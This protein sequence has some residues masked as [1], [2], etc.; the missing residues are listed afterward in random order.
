[1]HPLSNLEEKLA[2]LKWFN[3]QFEK[4]GKINFLFIEPQLSTKDMYKALFPFFYL[5]E[6]RGETIYSSTALTGLDKYDREL[7]LA[8]L[9]TRLTDEQI[10]FADVIFFPFTTQD[11]SEEY[12]RIKAKKKIICFCVDLNFYEVPKEHPLKKYFSEPLKNTLE[13]NVNN[14][15]YAVTSNQELA[16]YLHENKIK[17]NI[18]CIPYYIGQ[19][20]INTDIEADNS[21]LQVIGGGAK[22]QPKPVKVKSTGDKKPAPPIKGNEFLE[23]INIGIIYSDLVDYKPFMSTLKAIDKLGNVTFYI[24][25]YTPD[26][27]DVFKGI[28][29]NYVKKCSI[30]YYFKLLHS[31][32]LNLC[33]VPLEANLYNETSEGI[34]RFLECGIFG[35]PLIA[36]DQYPYNTVVKHNQNGFIYKEIDDIPSMVKGLSTIMPFVN[37]TVKTNLI[38]DVILNHSWVQEKADKIIEIF[39]KHIK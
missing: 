7:Q 15:H 10:D 32:K 25:G 2:D 1:M 22:I 38:N 34:S 39:L 9:H 24:I 28:H 23:P 3:G 5:W 19:D 36:P 8:G 12:D 31:L 35:I 33:L 29:Y 4:K 16:K 18:I 27:K 30:K 26:E 14:A 13:S 6:V 11:L 37:H 20:V 21:V 17:T